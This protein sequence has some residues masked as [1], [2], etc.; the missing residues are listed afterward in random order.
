MK[1]STISAILLGLAQ[2]YSNNRLIR[3]W[4]NLAVYNATDGNLTASFN[5]TSFPYIEN[6]S[7]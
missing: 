1:Y 2:A 4:D 5:L 6:V 3:V 7:L